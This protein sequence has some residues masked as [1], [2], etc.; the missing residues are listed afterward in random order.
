MIIAGHSDKY[1]R[2]LDNRVSYKMQSAKVTACK[3]Q[4]ENVKLNICIETA[5][6]NKRS[7]QCEEKF[8]Q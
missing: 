2:S 7:A 4:N 8:N 6:E 5:T 3:V 1:E